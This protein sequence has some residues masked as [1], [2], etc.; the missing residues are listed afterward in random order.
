MDHAGFVEDIVILS[1]SCVAPLARVN[2]LS[3]PQTRGVR[4]V[5]G[6]GM[7]VARVDNSGICISQFEEENFHL[8]SKFVLMHADAN[9]GED[10]SVS[11]FTP[12]DE[13][14]EI[15]E[16]TALTFDLPPPL[17]STVYNSPVYVRV[18][19]A[20]IHTKAQLLQFF[21]LL[22]SIFKHDSKPAESQSKKD[23]VLLEKSVAEENDEVVSEEEEDYYENMNSEE[24]EEN[25]DDAVVFS[26]D[27]EDDDSKNLVDDSSFKL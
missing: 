18:S 25:D 23:V 22:E 4:V 21:S 26:E 8:R 17:D 7:V 24:E 9:G 20:R 5:G 6:G 1:D 19:G 12:G 16:K 2:H 11:V 3:A 10:L 27:E 15:T 14:E 13:N